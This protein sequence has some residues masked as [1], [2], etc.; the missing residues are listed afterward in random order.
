MTA[1][2]LTSLTGTALTSRCHNPYFRRE[3]LKSLH[4]TLR[5]ETESIRDALRQ[6]TACTDSEA[7]VEIAIALRIVKGHHAAIHPKQELEEEYIVASG[8]DVKGRTEPWGL[9][10]I[11]P[12]LAHTPFLTVLQPLSAAV[13]AGS[14]V[15]LKV[16]SQR[17]NFIGT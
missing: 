13:A 1:T 10:Y 11:E 8:K 4:D 6:D 2:A 15:A 7:T 14:C 16:N 17:E 3:Q 9:V 12:N 5:K